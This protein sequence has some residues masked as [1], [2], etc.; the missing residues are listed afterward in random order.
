[1]Q[2]LRFREIALLVREVAEDDIRL[3]FDVVRLVGFL[4]RTRIRESI[5]RGC[6]IAGVKRRDGAVVHRLELCQHGALFHRELLDESR[7]QL[8]EHAVVR[9]RI[10]DEVVQIHEPVLEDAHQ[11][12]HD[13]DALR[14]VLRFLE[15]RGEALLQIAVF[16][17]VEARARVGQLAR[18]VLQPRLE[19]DSLIDQ[20]FDPGLRHIDEILPL[21]LCNRRASSLE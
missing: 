17:I 7:D 6:Q 5:T 3:V 4:G 16:V 1:M 15:Q 18:L 11:L 2:L 12:E 9:G 14:V 10:D 8:R 21:P 13:G 19:R 20:C